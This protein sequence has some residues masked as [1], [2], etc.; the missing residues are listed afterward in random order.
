MS[1]TKKNVITKPNNI[2][3]CYHMKML[4]KPLRLYQWWSCIVFIQI[5]NRLIF[6]SN[7]TPKLYA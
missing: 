5:Q 6:F 1:F 2:L 4:F 7:I 3:I